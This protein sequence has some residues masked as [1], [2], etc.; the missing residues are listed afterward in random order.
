[1][2]ADLGEP[3]N[4]V[5][6]GGVAMGFLVASLLF[7]RFWRDTRDRLFLLFALSFALEGV[8]RAVLALSPSPSEGQP[9]FYVV[10]F[11]TFLLI[12]GAIVDKNMNERAR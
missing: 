7:L 5:L 9:F 1:V 12:I 3:V 6:L 10:R 8:N 4:L 2:G 11:I